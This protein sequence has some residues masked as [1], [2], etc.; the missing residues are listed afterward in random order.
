MLLKVSGSVTYSYLYSS[1]L[2]S[3]LDNVA[4]PKV[5]YPI[6]LGYYLPIW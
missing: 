4:P 6:V 3:G 1:S 5:Y 2:K